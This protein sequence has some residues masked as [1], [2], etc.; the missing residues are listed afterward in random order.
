MI[1]A[2]HHKGYDAFFN[3]YIHRILK[4]DFHRIEIHGSWPAGTNSELVI[5]NHVSW[6]DGF[7]VYYLNRR[8]SHKRLFVMMLEEQLA[9]RMFLSR[10]GGFSV[11]PRH[12]SVVESLDYA[13]NKLVNP[14]NLVVMYPQGEIASFSAGVLSF[15]K[16]FNRVVQWAG[17]KRVLFYV[18]LIDYF[19]NRKPTLTFYLGHYGCEN[20]SGSETE[21]AFNAF[22]TEA[23]VQ[24][25]QKRS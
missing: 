6:W 17:L 15:Q 10:I 1:P 18:A 21:N 5:G 7:W 3:W 22:Y 2:R 4:N 25:A 9:P 23:V 12:R 19:S 11:N 20:S 24:Q 14:G 8:F 16:G 13:V